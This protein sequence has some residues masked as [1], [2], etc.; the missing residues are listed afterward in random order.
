M[1]IDEC[2][3]IA[4]YLQQ[5]EPVDYE[6]QRKGASAI[7]WLI[8][9]NRQLQAEIEALKTE[10]SFFQKE[11]STEELKLATRYFDKAQEK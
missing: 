9:Q 3:E 10:L 6:E 7:W 2:F 8:E 4:D 5:T 1:N 11:K